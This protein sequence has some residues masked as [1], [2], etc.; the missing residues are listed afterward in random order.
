VFE[1]LNLHART[2]GF[3][4]LFVL[5]EWWQRRRW[6]PFAVGVLPWPIRWAAYT[7]FFWA[8]LLFGTHHTEEFIYFRF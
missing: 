1:Q 8:I 6:N 5:I 7:A 4:G 2:F 3:L